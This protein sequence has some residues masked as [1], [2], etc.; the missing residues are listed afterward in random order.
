MEFGCLDNWATG[1]ALCLINGTN[2]AIN[3]LA[4]EDASRV[5]GMPALDGHGIFG[6]TEC[7]LCSVWAL[8]L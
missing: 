1:C 7:L 3:V 8:P 5:Y 4:D 6:M 2:R